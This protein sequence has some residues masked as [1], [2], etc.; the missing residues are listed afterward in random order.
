[1]Y[2]FEKDTNEIISMANKKKWPQ[3][4]VMWCDSAEPDRIKQWKTAGYKA[5]PVVKEKT[6][7]KKYQATQIDWL[8]QRRIYV[9]PSCTNTMKE[10][11]QWKWKRNEQNGE[12]LDEPVPF[13]DDAM[14]A[15]RYG[16]E[17]WRKP[18][19]MKFNSVSG[20]LI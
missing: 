2:V 9:D 6:T 12:Y 13:F 16:A 18:M 10:L 3:D 19:A 11:E 4:I 5:R 7:S 1:M 8:K 20:G 14:S 15:L 17:G